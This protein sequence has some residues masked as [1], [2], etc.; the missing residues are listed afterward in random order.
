M[1]PLVE[2]MWYFQLERGVGWPAID[3]GAG[4]RCTEEPLLKDQTKKVQVEEYVYIYFYAYD[5]IMYVM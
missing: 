5:H 4:S 2:L 3:W 1:K